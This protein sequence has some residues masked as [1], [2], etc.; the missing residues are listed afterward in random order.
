M[1][2]TFEHVEKVNNELSLPGDKSI[3]HRAV[4][5]AS[6]AGGISTISNCSNSEDVRSTIN[7]F[8]ELG[9]SFDE[10]GC[11]I[12]ITGKGYKGF[13]KPRDVL[14]AGNS[15]TTSRLLSGILV[16]QDF[17]S[18]ITGDE[19]LSLRPMNRIIKPLGLMGAKI[20]ASA[21]G[22]LPLTINPSNELHPI[23]YTLEVASAQVKSALLLCAIW[24]RSLLFLRLRKPEIILKNF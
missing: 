4:M 21:Q 7:C 24:R 12:I 3:S 16:A 1:N 6:L 10:N 2:Q 22:T 23:V 14:Y 19:S 11:E 5:F 8:T 9:C 20:S 13:T 17:E 15:G 18:V